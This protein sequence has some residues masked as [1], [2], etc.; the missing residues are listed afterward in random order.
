[1]GILIGSSMNPPA[2]T[3]IEGGTIRQPS[4]PARRAVLWS[5]QVSMVALR[6]AILGA[7]RAGLHRR[8][9]E[10]GEHGCAAEPINALRIA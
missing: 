4:V 7:G 8:D 2:T 9:A 1:M 3:S 5:S 6:T 10:S